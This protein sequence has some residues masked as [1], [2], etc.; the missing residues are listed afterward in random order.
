MACPFLSVV[1]PAFNEES[2]IVDTLEQVLEYLRPQTYGWEVL[3]VD[4]GSTDATATL[5]QRLVESQP[6]G[7][8]RLLSLA[9]GG[10]GWAVKRGMLEASGQ[11]RFMCDAD[12]SMPI[13]QVARFLPPQL[14]EYD[15][16]IGSREVPGARKIGEPRRRTLMGRG[17]SLLVRALA[18]PGLVDTQCGFKCFRAEAAARLFGQQ[19]L[20]GFAFDVEVLFLARKQGLRMIEV[21][22]DWYYRTQSKVRPVRDSASMIR[23]ILHIRWN[24]IRGRYRTDPAGAKEL[25]R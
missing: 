24:Y 18:L 22:I 13:E 21:P 2:R 6:G 15:V 1:I 8:L 3:V 11:Y 20:H 23:D 10:K 16:A 5:V 12:L 14:Q 7:A 9:H 17:F 25:A 19:R 4:D